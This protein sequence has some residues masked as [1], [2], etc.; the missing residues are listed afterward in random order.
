MSEPPDSDDAQ[1]PAGDSS[2]TPRG[3]KSQEPSGD[4]S[5]AV[6]SGC[7]SA[8]GFVLLTV[9]LSVALA[10]QSKIAYPIVLA[11]IAACG[12]PLLFVRNWPVRGIGIGLLLG[13]GALTIFTGG[14]C[15]GLDV[16][17]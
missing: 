11:A 2:G 9:V 5:W 12:I 3:K 15:T 17:T 10:T 14:V 16:V 1:Q 6:V 13:W 8:V 4:R 7:L